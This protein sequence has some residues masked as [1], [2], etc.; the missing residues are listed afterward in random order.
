MIFYHLLMKFKL[1]VFLGLFFPNIICSLLSQIIVD[2]K[3]EVSNVD[4][5]LINNELIITYDLLNAKSN[6]KFIISVNISTESGKLINSKTFKGDV[7]EN[8]TA[9]YSK[10]IIWSISDDIVYLDDKIFVEVTATH[11]NPKIIQPTS[12][13]KAIL[14]STLFPGYGSAKTTLKTYHLI[15]GIAGYGCVV[16]Y[17]SYKNKSDKSFSDYQSANTTS[18]RDKFYNLSISEKQTS[19]ALLYTGTGMWLLDYATILISEN[20]SHRKGLKSQISYIGPDFGTANNY[21]GIS[22]VI[23]F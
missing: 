13:S 14:L 1:L 10:K 12:K 5:N 6:E 19:K 3:A 22:M 7:G 9:G 4:F 8:I 18:E 15:K 21:I 23:K 11:Q 16:G 2:T 17:V 20:R